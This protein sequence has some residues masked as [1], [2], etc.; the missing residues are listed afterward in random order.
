VL[1]AAEITEEEEEGTKEIEGNEMEEEKEKIKK[2]QCV[3]CCFTQI[4]N[5]VGKPSW[6]WPRGF[7]PQKKQQML[8]YQCISTPEKKKEGIKEGMWKER[9]APKGRERK[10]E[11]ET[12]I[13]L[14]PIKWGEGDDFR[15]F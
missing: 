9:K 3:T 1:N 6:P 4:W 15:L 7:R 10:K 8:P 12:K 2:E 13:K 14:D 5:I 11:K